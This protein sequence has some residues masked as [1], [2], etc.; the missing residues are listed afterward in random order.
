MDKNRI[1]S[2]RSGDSL[3]AR[4]PEKAERSESKLY[5]LWCGTRGWLSE[6]VTGAGFAVFVSISEEFGN[7]LK[8]RSPLR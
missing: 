4:Q 3:T 1:E 7:R 2:E 6:S 5:V 8:S